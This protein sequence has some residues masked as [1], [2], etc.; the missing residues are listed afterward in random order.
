ME[1]TKFE[2]VLSG[3]LIVGM[4]SVGYLVGVNDG[5]NITSYTVSDVDFSEPVPMPEVTLILD[6]EKEE[7]EEPIIGE[8]V[9]TFGGHC[10]TTYQCITTQTSCYIKD[11]SCF[12][13]SCPAH[14]KN[15]RVTRKSKSNSPQTTTT[16]LPPITIT[17]VPEPEIIFTPENPDPIYCCGGG[18]DCKYDIRCEVSG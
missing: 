14:E 1:P 18:G 4:I 11:E 6:Y 9:K 16:T 10:P 8:P 7:V 3:V 12:C 2:L 17:P 15:I 5:N 13:E